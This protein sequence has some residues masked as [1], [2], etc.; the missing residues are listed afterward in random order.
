MDAAVHLTD[1]E[2]AVLIDH[3]HR[4]QMHVRCGLCDGL[5]GCVWLYLHAGAQIAERGLRDATTV[6]LRMLQTLL[7]T[8]H[9]EELSWYWRS[10]CLEHVGVPIAP[11]RS[12]VGLHDPI[13]MQAIEAAVQ[14]ARG[15]LSRAPVAPDRLA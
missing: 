11:L 8:A 14:R 7:L 9:D 10:V 12:L 3:W 13:A 15:G 5:P 1:T 2:S 4:L 6:H